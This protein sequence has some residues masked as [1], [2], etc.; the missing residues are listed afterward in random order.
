MRVKVDGQLYDVPDDATPDEIDQITK[1]PQPTQSPRQKM[2]NA[3]NR[4]LP[5]TPGLSPAENEKQTATALGMGMGM[6]MPNPLPIAGQ[7]L[8]GTGKMIG[9]GARGAFRSMFPKTAEPALDPILNA[10]KPGPNPLPA[11][12]EAAELV[13]GV[14]KAA[15]VYN[16][17]RR[18]TQGQSKPP[19]NPYPVPEAVPAA[20]QP[21]AAAAPSPAPAPIGVSDLTP[22]T[23]ARLTQALQPKPSTLSI[24][25]QAGRAKKVTELTKAI[26]AN[27][28]AHLGVDPLDP[29]FA[30]SLAEMPQQWWEGMAQVA[31]INK[32]SPESIR[33]AVAFFRD[34]AAQVTTAAK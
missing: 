17:L 21:Q 13:P 33:Q 24:F 19:V 25:E 28:S 16:I 30:E 23:Q 12:P 9:E 10:A 26:D 1:P 27:A 31:K 11:I 14:G 22:S 29:R 5:Q 34:R 15:K 4:L 3:L 7:I 32:P 20:P 6:T 8:R 18:A 2:V